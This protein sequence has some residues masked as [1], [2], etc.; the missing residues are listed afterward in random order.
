MDA[1]KTGNKE[2]RRSSG[3][4]IRV[5]ILAGIPVTARRLELAGVSTVVLEGGVVLTS[6]VRISIGTK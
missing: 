6:P 4:A 1:D 3:D 2:H 5:R